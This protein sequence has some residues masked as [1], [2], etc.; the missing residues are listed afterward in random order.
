MVMP[1]WPK[2]LGNDFLLNTQ[3]KMDLNEFLAQKFIQSH[4]TPNILIVAYRDTVLVSSNSELL[5]LDIQGISINDCQSEEEDQRIVRHTLHCLSDCYQF[6][7]GTDVLMLI[8]FNIGSLNV[9]PKADIYV[10]MLKNQNFYNIKDITSFIG[11]TICKALSFYYSF[12]G[13]DTTFF[14]RGKCKIWDTWHNNTHKDEITS[15]FTKLS[16]QP[17]LITDIGMNILEQ[18]VIEIYSVSKS[19]KYTSLGE[20]RLQKFITSIDNN[21]CNL[22]PSCDALLQHAKRVCYQARYLWRETIS[23]VELP[24]PTIWGWKRS[25]SGTLLPLWVAELCSIQIDTFIKTCECY[26]ELCKNC[27]CSRSGLHCLTFCGCSRNC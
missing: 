1:L 20:M 15:V 24:D 13:C 3:N 8:V 27:K 25:I 10:K 18:F 16:D 14:K 5:S 17:P 22:P 19:F 7:Q 6:K 26:K 21:L 4:N 11:L 23:N 12:A 9:T 2:T